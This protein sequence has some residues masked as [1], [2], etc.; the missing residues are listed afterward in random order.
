MMRPPFFRHVRKFPP[1]PLAPPTPK[2][3]PMKS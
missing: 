1:N 3:K 2:Q